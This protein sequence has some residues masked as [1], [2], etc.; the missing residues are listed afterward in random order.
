MEVASETETDADQRSLAE[1]ELEPYRGKRGLLEQTLGGHGLELLFLHPEVNHS[2]KGACEFLGYALTSVSNFT[3]KWTMLGLQITKRDWA[4]HQHQQAAAL[5]AGL[6][7]AE[8]L[9][10]YAAMTRRPEFAPVFRWR[11]P[12]SEEYGILV[13]IADLHFGSIHVDVDRFLSLC[14][15]LHDNPSARWMMLGDLLE[16]KTRQAPGYDESGIAT[17]H[18]KVAVIEAL[19]PVAKQG[20]VILAGNHD[21]RPSREA[22]MKVTTH[23]E[24]IAKELG[25][26]FGQRNTHCRVIL[27]RGK[28]EQSYTGYVTHGSSGARTPGG[29]I[30]ALERIANNVRCDFVATAHVH[31][32]A[33]HERVLG[34]LSPEIEEQGGREV[35]RVQMAEVQEIITGSFLRH[36]QG[37]YARDGDMSPSSLGTVSLH[38][39][40][41]HHSLHARK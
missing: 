6:T 36:E 1:R 41:T 10:Y 22:G 19:R 30:A 23:A 35:S 20:L 9:N 32:K 28:L 18:A 3:D 33:T 21:M 38:C 16:T 31:S 13:F 5:T 25:I 11:L 15:W 37:S 14:Q 7:P 26:H 27:Q 2:P 17:E 39:Y 4:R 24:E 34:E 29:R 12:K 40:V 8:I